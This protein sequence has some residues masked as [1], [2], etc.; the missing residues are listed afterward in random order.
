[1]PPKKRNLA[2][3][4]KRLRAHALSYPEAHEEFPWGERVIKVRRKIFV[5]LGTAG[6]ELSL[7]MKLPASQDLA[8]LLPYVT[9]TA[10]G[11]GKSGWVTVRCAGAGTEPAA[12]LLEAWIDEGY[13]A[14]A[15][16]KLVAQIDARSRP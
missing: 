9:P 10:Y 5:F 8:L 15:P 6:K 3:L 2:A 16:K 7:G 4:E 14:V 1:M 11:L 13:R 12:D